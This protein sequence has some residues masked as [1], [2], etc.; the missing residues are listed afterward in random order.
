MFLKIS[1][2]FKHSTPLAR[3]PASN[4]CTRSW[5]QH[6]LLEL[7]LFLCP[8]TTH[9]EP[10]TGNSYWV[11]KVFP[12]HCLRLDRNETTVGKHTKGAK[13]IIPQDL[14]HCSS[15][16]IKNIKSKNQWLTFWHKTHPGKTTRGRRVG[17]TRQQRRR[18]RERRR[19]RR[20]KRKR[21]RRRKLIFNWRNWHNPPWYTPISR[22]SFWVPYRPPTY[23]HSSLQL[24][25]HSMEL[26][27]MH[28]FEFCLIPFCALPMPNKVLGTL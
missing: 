27:A 28:T 22:C 17:M 3:L 10:G 6:Y 26:K 4:A 2:Y 7:D 23:P 15:F 5:W 24:P 11:L 19:K 25:W 12:G 14:C 13:R 21:G 9:K 16:T 20:R 18:K 8:E 1:R